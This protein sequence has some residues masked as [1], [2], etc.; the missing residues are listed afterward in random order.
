MARKEAESAPTPRAHVPEPVVLAKLE[1]LG[2]LIRA[3]R[4]Q[5]GVRQE[6]M[7]ER[8][9]LSRASLHKAESGVPGVA[10]GIVATIVDRLG[11][12]LDPDALSQDELTELLEIEAGRE[13]VR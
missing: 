6:E 2:K 12:P 4:L 9:G 10:L 13:R 3:K 7:A 8:L 11:L 1:R 5:Q